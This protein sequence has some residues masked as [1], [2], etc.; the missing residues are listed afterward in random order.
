MQS[1]LRH[2]EPTLISFET[3]NDLSRQPIA[4]SRYALVAQDLMHTSVSA[5]ADPRAERGEIVCFG[6]PRR[7][8]LGARSS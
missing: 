6:R 1:V 3:L 7:N 4:H 8:F 5:V 2:R